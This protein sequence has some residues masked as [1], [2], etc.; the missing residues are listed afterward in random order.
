[1]KGWFLMY[2]KILPPGFTERN[3]ILMKNYSTQRKNL[4]IAQ[5]KH[6]QKA[7][8]RPIM[9]LNLCSKGII[10]NNFTNFACK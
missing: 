7:F 9:K 8:Y 3:G 1:M 10:R 6:Y 2:N 4:S 5:N